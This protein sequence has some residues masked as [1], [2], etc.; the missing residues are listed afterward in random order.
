[1]DA[2]NITP[3]KNAG[4]RTL[5]KACI[6][7]LIPIWDLLIGNPEMQIRHFAAGAIILVRA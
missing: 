7:F 3:K 4:F 1:M 5:A 2:Q 6:V